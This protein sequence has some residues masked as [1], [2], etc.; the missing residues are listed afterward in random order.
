[1]QLYVE[2]LCL[3][4]SVQPSWKP[5]Q[6]NFKLAIL[7]VYAYTEA[8]RYEYGHRQ[9]KTCPRGFANNKGADQPAHKRSLISAFII[10]LLESI[11]SRLASSEISR[12]FLASLC[13]WKRRLVETSL[14][15]KPRRLVL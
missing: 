14:Y 13:S 12:N 1:M 7:N 6:N 3:S 15:R 9:E 2:N 8:S 4:K 11:V 5:E 10:R